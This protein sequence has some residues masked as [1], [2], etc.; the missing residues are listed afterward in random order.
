MGKARDIFLHAVGKLPPKRW[1]AYVAEVCGEDAELEQLVM[2]LLQVHREAGSFLDRPAVATGAF[3]PNLRDGTFDARPDDFLGAEIGSY[4]LLQQIG[5]GGMGAVFMAEQVHPV[6]RKVA[7][8]LI[9][10]G[11]DSRHF[12]ARFEAE[13]QALALMDHPNIAKVLDAGTTENGLPYF[14]ME[15][16]KGMPITRYC[17]EHHLTPRQRLEL[18]VPVCQAVQHA[19]QKGIIHRDLKPTNVL[20]CQYDGHPVPKVIDF[21]VAKATGRK[22]TEKTLFTEFGQIVGTLEYMSPEQAELNQLDVDARS[23][24]YSLGVILY[25]LLTGTTPLERRQLKEATFLEV[26]RLIRE[27]EPPKPSTR[28]ST[29]EGMPSIAANRGLE[30]RKLSALMR[31]ELDWIVMR[32][33]EKN[34][35]R[36]YVTPNGLARDIER[37]LND[38]TVEACP[39][40]AFHRSRKFVRR[41]RGPLLAA[42]VILFCLVA[43]VIATS[44]ALVWAVR[45]RD[46]K[47]SAL[48]AEIT[49]KEAAIQQRQEKEQA[50]TAE[51]KARN[52]EKQA[53]DKALVA[54]RALTDNIVE[55]QMA[56]GPNLSDENKE[57][58]RTIILQFEGFA[59]ITA[60]DV[61][62]RSIRAEGYFR[63]GVMRYRLGEYVE[64]EAAYAEA[65]ALWKQLADDFPT[66]PEHRRE[67]S[68]ILHNL[69]AL[70]HN[71]GRP[72]EA[73]KA[74]TAALLIRKQLADDFPARPEFRHDL[75]ASHTNRGY[76]LSD[77]GRLQEA[78]AAYTVALALNEQLVLEFPD[79]PKFRQDLATCRENM[80]IL[81]RETG[82]LKE[83]EEALTDVHALRK[84]LAAD[85][86]TRPQFHYELSTSHNN[87]GLVLRDMARLKDAELAYAAALALQ[88]Q[89][90]ADF[91]TRPEFRSGLAATHFNLGVLLIETGRLKEAEEAFAAG[92][93]LFKQLAADFPTRPEFRQ[94]LAESQTRLGRLV[95]NP[96]WVKEAHTSYAAAL[97]IRKQLAADFPGQ[98]EYQRDLVASQCNLA[99]LLA[100]TGQ[101]KEAEE[102]YSASLAIAKQLVAANPNRPEL[103]AQLARIHQNLGGVFIETG[104]LQLAEPAYAA[105][106]ALRKQLAAD[107]PALLAH[108][109]DLAGS[110]VSLGHLLWQTG[111]ISKAEAAFADALAI[112][113]QLAT[114]FSAGP[115]F[116]NS[117]AATHESLGTL[118]RDSGRLKE[119][120]T[121]YAAA[122]ELR[123]QLAAD[124]PTLPGYRQYLARTYTNLGLLLRYAGRL[125]EAQ[126]AYSTSLALQK[127]LASDF[128]SIPEIRQDLARTQNDLGFFLYT[129]GRL[130]EADE[131]YAAA[132]ALRKQAVAEFPHQP[133]WQND[134]AGTCVNRAIL[135]LGE[136]DFKAARA[137]LEEAAPYHESALKAKPRH[138]TYRL[139]YQNHLFVLIR[140]HAGLGDQTGAK[141]AAQ[142]LC[143]LGWNPPVDAYNAACCL[144]AC[145]PII[146]KNEQATQD[147]RVKEAAFYGDEAMKML[148]G[149]VAR[150]W[151]YAAPMKMN[152]DLNAVRNR[153]DFKE[154]LA[155]LE[156]GEKRVK[157]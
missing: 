133:E 79:R 93:T 150:G 37:Y 46:A 51:M 30:P 113:K 128:A 75:A 148:K 6:Q 63:V 1:N 108:R 90:V 70:L 134:L 141:Q 95:G 19:H 151:K 16:V 23:D 130:R 44:V 76:V 118:L 65:L 152:P 112:M 5:E 14:V 125:N 18:F 53:R 22:L 155:G 66:R 69:G 68:A 17:D 2:A 147:A 97:T 32:S 91:P 71:T 88:K 78:V 12:I 15:L 86:P 10:S 67:Q 114:D 83:A 138:P 103:R 145:I 115:A 52:A 62:S 149:A 34:R 3:T 96:D 61:D 99:D 42:S 24:I 31:G 77:M 109:Q 64:A 119:A 50:L 153:P 45:E 122:L 56:R 48:N 98:L 39:P 87:M 4:K 135:Y 58:L 102:I 143:D 26:L 137:C 84:Q 59:A 92:R 111:E 124:F 27:A 11:L 41:N 139:F 126:D 38:E 106:L 117:Q 105:A 35:D 21:G 85:F 144:S 110:Y 74:Y 129:R 116:R 8:K 142:K 154:L 136:R 72:I 132:L 127:Q 157:D 94:R 57:F 100:A 60:D 36:R 29:A 123:K 47:A 13:R 156:A 107:F 28:I 80:G 104:R 54:L 82:R 140:T 7:L 43:G 25:E 121:A 89:L 49:A 81:L 101:P 131:A 9:R 55:N 40:S 120:E 146:Q 20:V 33:L 73:E